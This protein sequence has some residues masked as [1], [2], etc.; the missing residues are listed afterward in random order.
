MTEKDRRGRDR[1]RSRGQRFH[2]A[3][4]KNG[5]SMLVSKNGGEKRFFIGID[6]LL[7]K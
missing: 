5:E 2:R 6:A 7:D 1:P 4:S 3:V